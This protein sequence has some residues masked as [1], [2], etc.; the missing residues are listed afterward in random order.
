MLNHIGAQQLSLVNWVL[1]IVMHTFNLSKMVVVVVVLMV[2]IM[3]LLLI[4]TCHQD[5]WRSPICTGAQ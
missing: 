5:K 4:K 1:G 2:M 3:L